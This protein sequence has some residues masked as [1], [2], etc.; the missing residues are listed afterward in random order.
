MNTDLQNSH[1][2]A[3]QIDQWLVEG[4]SVEAQGHVA[5]CRECEEKLAEAR[6]PLAIFRSAVVAWSESQP[7]GK[8]SVGEEKRGFRQWALVD[9]MPVASVAFAVLVLAVFL[10]RGGSLLRHDVAP[11]FEAQF[12]AKSP[13]ISDTVLMEQVDEEVSETVPDAMAPLTDLVGWDSGTAAT[14]E[15]AAKHGVKKKAAASRGKAHGRGND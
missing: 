4:P 13:V 6:E 8:I 1:L 10:L 3:G 7:V 15:S 5:A 11:Q 2:S 12:E 9:W 14:T